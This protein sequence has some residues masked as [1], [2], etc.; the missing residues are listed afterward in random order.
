MQTITRKWLTACCAITRL[1]S[2]CTTFA[3]SLAATSAGCIL[4]ACFGAGDTAHVDPSHT[5]YQSTWDRPDMDGGREGT[6]DA[7][8]TFVLA[9]A[10]STAAHTGCI[11]SSGSGKLAAMVVAVSRVFP[12]SNSA[13]DERIIDVFVP[14]GAVPGAESREF[15]CLTLTT[16]TA[17]EAWDGTAGTPSAERQR[18]RVRW[19]PQE[20]QGPTAVRAQDTRARH[21]ALRSFGAAPNEALEKHFDQLAD[22]RNIAP[23]CRQQHVSGPPER[24]PD[25]S[26]PPGFSGHQN[27]PIF[28]SRRN[29]SIQ[30]PVCRGPSP[31][32]AISIL[33][34]HL[35][36][37]SL[38]YLSIHREP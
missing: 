28:R 6:H 33:P 22:S 20:Y 1:P 11:V 23:Y 19:H 26:R 25:L 37:S 2:K 30:F 31:R 34:E 10:V 4:I 9:L 13:P 27:T 17:S 36:L 32:R 35:F 24:A 38:A 5:R 12:G 16:Q 29:Y 14:M 21:Y 15:S 3:T 8:D 7:T 18:N